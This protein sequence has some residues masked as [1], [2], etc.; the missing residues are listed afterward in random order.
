MHIFNFRTDSR[1]LQTEKQVRTVVVSDS[2]YLPYDFDLAVPVPLPAKIC[3]AEL[4][5]NQN[6][7]KASYGVYFRLNVAGL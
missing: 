6:Q 2:D 4:V 7:Q 1:E 5:P 3:R